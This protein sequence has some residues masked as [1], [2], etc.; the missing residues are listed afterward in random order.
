MERLKDIAEA[1]KTEAAGETGK[2]WRPLERG[3]YLKL[4]R[5][6]LEWVLSLTRQGVK[7]SD[8][9]L[10]ICRAAFGVPIEAEV[11]TEEVPPFY[12]RRVRWLGVSQAELF[13]APVPPAI[14][15]D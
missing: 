5:D 11:E 14:F 8:L 12:I 10:S 3:L 7:P 4:W 1:M 13:D 15:R 9:E 2:A 6:G